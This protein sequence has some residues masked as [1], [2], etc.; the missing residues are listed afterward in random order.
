MGAL[1][2][3]LEDALL[4]HSLNNGRA[5][6]YTPPDTLYIA[7][8]TSSGG[9]EN[10]TEGE[11]TEITGGSYARQALNGSDNYFTPASG[12][13]AENYDDI[14][15]PVAT[16][17][18]GVLTHVAVMDALTGGNVLYWG[19]LTQTKQIDSGDQYKFNAGTLVIGLD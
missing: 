2:N 5:L 6:T 10:N 13:E 12:G 4:D 16:D 19:E 7:L 1:S 8:F 15:F 17:D 14:E 3:Y 11:Q 18:W 9:L